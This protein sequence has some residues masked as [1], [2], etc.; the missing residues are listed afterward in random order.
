MN[1]KEVFNPFFYDFDFWNFG[2]FWNICDFN[3][4]REYKLNIDSFYSENMREFWT[5]YR[6]R[7]I[8]RI[9]SGTYYLYVISLYAL[10]IGWK[11]CGCIGFIWL[12]W[13]INRIYTG[14]AVFHD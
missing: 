6:N 7:N 3:L 9:K 14:N 1:I 10:G 5:A 11:V 12:L 8:I 4:Y 2:N 13:A